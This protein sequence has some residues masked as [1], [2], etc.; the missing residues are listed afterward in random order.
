LK[1][2]VECISKSKARTPYVFGV[3]VTLATA[4]KEGLILAMR[5]MPGNRDGN[6]L[7]ETVE[8]ASI[9][10]DKIPKTV[11]VDRGYQGVRV[12]GVKILR[13]GQRGGVTR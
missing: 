1:S 3:K 5:S 11:I 12:E 10:T 2:P 13:S 7:A 4:L 9:L 6:T 8:Q